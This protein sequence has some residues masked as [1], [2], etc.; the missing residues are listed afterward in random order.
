MFPPFPSL[1]H[2]LALATIFL[3]AA[4]SASAFAQQASQVADV[5]STVAPMAAK[6]L[7]GMP[8]VA[9]NTTG[10]FVIT[11]N[12]LRFIGHDSFAEIDSSRILSVSTG[13]ERIETGGTGGRIVRAVIPYG[14]GL[15]LATVTQKSV[16]LLT[17]EYLDPSGEYHGAV[18]SLDKADMLVAKADLTIHPAPVERTSDLKPCPAWKIQPN[19]VQVN[20]IGSDDESGFPAEDRVLLYEHLIQQLQSE[21]SVQH[22][23]RAG[24]RSPQ[25]QCAEFTVTVRPT[26]FTKGNQAVRASVGPLGHFVGTTRLTFHLTIAAQNGISVRDE[27]LKKSEGADSDSLNV[28]KVIGKTIVKNL[29]KSRTQLRR[30]QTT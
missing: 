27:D 2:L 4:L 19:T 12:G 29:K 25:A 9:P 28:T 22:V 18:F 30:T 3:S 8:G 11:R 15:A 26:V 7:I 5:S 17:V 14:G 20:V 24:D 16:G 21:K 1:R 23:F 10:K 6:A 13:D